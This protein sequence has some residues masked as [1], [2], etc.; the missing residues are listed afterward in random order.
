MKLNK[1]KM[2]CKLQNVYSSCAASRVWHWEL[3]ALNLIARRL[4]KT[5]WS[6]RAVCASA[7]AGAASS[8]SY[9]SARFKCQ[10]TTKPGA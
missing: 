5:K 2:L 10:S 6:D 3:N 8:S 7:G 9:A 4:N 1:L